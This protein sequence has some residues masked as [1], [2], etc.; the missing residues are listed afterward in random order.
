MKDNLVFVQ[1]KILKI[2]KNY[3][4]NNNSPFLKK[5]YFA[6]FEDSDG[7]QLIKNK[8]YNLRYNKIKKIFYENYNIF[9]KSNLKIIANHQNKKYY[10]NLIITWGNKSSFSSNGTFYD[11]YFSTNSS[12]Y[13][14]TY[15][16]IYSNSKINSKKLDNNLA[17][18]YPEKNFQNYFKFLKIFILNFTYIVFGLNKKII[19]QDLIIS[20]YINNFIFNRKNLSKLKN[21]I[22]PYEGQAFQKRV[23]AK[24]KIE[25][26][27]LTTYGFDHTAP[28]SIS[29]QLYYTKGSPDKLLVS[30]INVKK[31]YSRF[32]NWSPKKIQLTFPTRYIHYNKR[33]FSNKLFLPYNLDEQDKITDNIDFFLKNLKNKSMKNFYI[34]VHPIKEKD[35]YHILLKEKIENIKKRYKKKFSNTSNNEI[36]IAVGFTTTPLVA[37]EFDLS[38]LHICPNPE[39]DTYLNYFWPDIKIKKINKFC[40][41]YSIKKSGK[42]LNFKNKNKIMEILND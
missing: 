28:H 32:Y 13:K 11:K 2:V 29:T 10:N 39:F 12:A 33:D 37:L 25:N 19:D 16:I 35:N 41:L 24:Q 14:N 20:E 40:F 6:F 18:I 31:C 1:K 4:A 7:S 26:K 9:N 22:M 34:N 5:N 36:V 27:K 15:W 23:F 3:F 38:V 30:G 8:I 17:I 42:Y 21:L